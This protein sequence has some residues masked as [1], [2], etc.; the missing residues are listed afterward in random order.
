MILDKTVEE[1]LIA[2]VPPAISQ[3]LQNL[4]ARFYVGETQVRREF[5]FNGC[6][7]IV[8]D[9]VSATFSMN[10]YLSLLKLHKVSPLRRKQRD[11]LGSPTEEK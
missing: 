2:G 8:D 7:I 1:F 4:K 9:E 10:T 11:E 3:F 6:K 5:T